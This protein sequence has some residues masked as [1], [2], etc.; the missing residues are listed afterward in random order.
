MWAKFKQYFWTSHTLYQYANVLAKQ[1]SQPCP[2]S[3]LQ[4]PMFSQQVEVSTNYRHVLNDHWSCHCTDKRCMNFDC[5]IGSIS[6]ARKLQRWSLN[7]IVSA[8]AWTYHW[9]DVR[10]SR[11]LRITKTKAMK[12]SNK[13]NF[14]IR[15]WKCRQDFITSLGTS[16][17]DRIA[18]R[19]V[20]MSFNNKLL[21]HSNK[22]RSGSLS[23]ENLMLCFRAV[24]KQ[25]FMINQ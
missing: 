1:F 19:L 5:A 21:F 24:F 18:I 2:P 3:P 7:F 10:P 22:K 8:A 9:Q 12:K 17:K 23:T 6:R 25:L 4:Q 20:N 13:T 11:D 14:H 16:Q 15:L